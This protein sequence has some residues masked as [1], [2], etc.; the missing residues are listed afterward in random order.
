MFINVIVSTRLVEIAE[1]IADVV[2]IWLPMHSII[3]F[4]HS[5]CANAALFLELLIKSSRVI[6]GGFL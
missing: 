3:S 5:T 4:D 6:Y 1:V 2:M